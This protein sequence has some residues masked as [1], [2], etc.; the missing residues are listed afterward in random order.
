VIGIVPDQ[1]L[2]DEL[3]CRIDGDAVPDTDRDILKA[4]V[5]DRYHGRG[6]G[7]GLVHG[8][9]LK[10]GALAGSVAHDSHNIVAVGVEDTDIIRAIREVVDLGG[11]MVAVAGDTVASLPLECAGLMS[12]LPYGEVARRQGDLE[13]RAH[14]FGAIENPFMYL[15]FLALTVIPH[16]RVTER[17]LFDVAAFSDAPLFLP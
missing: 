11:G 14:E 1:I 10:E 9:S 5:T 12:A 7:V 6:S 4:V 2:T 8:F 17:G 15:S 3:R 16:L 13:D